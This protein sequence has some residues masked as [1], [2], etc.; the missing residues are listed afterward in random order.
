MV[1]KKCRENPEDVFFIDSS[2]F[3][4]KVKTQNVLRDEHIDKIITTFR[5]RTEEKNTA[6]GQHLKK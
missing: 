6:N 1:F 3:F 5:N 4:E 2:Q